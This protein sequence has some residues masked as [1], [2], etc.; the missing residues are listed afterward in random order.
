MGNSL[1]LN[2][3][4]GYATEN[5]EMTERNRMAGSGLY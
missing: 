4:L 5:I 1:F 2:A 3:V